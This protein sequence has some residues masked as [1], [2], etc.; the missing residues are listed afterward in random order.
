M[1]AQSVR[2][3]IKDNLLHNPG[4]SLEEEIDRIRENLLTGSWVS[5]L[6]FTVLAALEWI[7]LFRNA[8]PSPVPVTVI[9]ASLWV[10]TGYRLYRVRIQLRYLKQGRDGEK[11]VGQ[12]LESLR[13]MGAHVFHDVPARG[14]NVD[15]VII[16]PQGIYAI[17][18]KTLSKPAR[19]KA[20]IWVN[21]GN[22]SANGRQVGRKPVEQ[23]VAVSQWLRNELQAST[24][25]DFPVR[26][27]LL[28]PGWYVHP[29]RGS[30]GTGAW[31]LNPKALPAFVKSEPNKLSPEDVKLA[32]YHLSRYVR[33][34]DS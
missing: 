23:A 10:Y 6:F 12:Y 3:P 26:P 24:G 34:F 13:E 7:R 27:V 33:T 20:E 15:H 29:V 8:P 14:F 30:N 11:A 17:E 9:A 25:R 32:T 21:G 4:Q 18:T 16:A 31:V 19:G 2:S 1:R 28:F 22:V 5:A